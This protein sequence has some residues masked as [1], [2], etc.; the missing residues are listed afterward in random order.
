MKTGFSYTILRRAEDDPFTTVM[1]TLGNNDYGGW[2]P[3]L[4]MGGVYGTTL[5]KLSQRIIDAY[6]DHMRQDQEQ[7]K[8]SVLNH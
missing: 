8:P 2:L 1:S 3:F 4:M 6:K 7:Q 5:T